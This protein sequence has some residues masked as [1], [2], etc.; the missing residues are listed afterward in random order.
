MSEDKLNIKNSEYKSNT[1][2]LVG[3]FFIVSSLTTLTS[4]LSYN[5]IDPGWGI[6]NENL[7]TNYL[8]IFGSTLS[9]FIIRELGIFAGIFLS[10]TIL[11]LGLKLI[12]NRKLNLIFYRF[13]SLLILLFLSVII[14]EIINQ[15]VT[16]LYGDK[17][18]LFNFQT[19]GY[20]LYEYII[21]YFE[22]IS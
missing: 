7:P 2:F 16:K 3:L 17:F 14:S 9:S 18:P 5:S 10:L 6:V 15:N 8:G 22:N 20:L 11:L 4:I 21:K 12:K 13:I 1:L 19:K